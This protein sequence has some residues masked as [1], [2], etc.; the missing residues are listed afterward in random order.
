MK[1]G[2]LPKPTDAEVAILRVLWQR[3]PSTVREVWEQLNP[4][5]RT[6]Y[7]TTLKLMQIMFEK[8]LV[9][10]DD[11]NRSHVYAPAVSE[12]RTQQQVIGHLLERVFAGSAGK[13]VMQ[14]LAVKKASPAELAEIRKLLDK[15]EEGGGA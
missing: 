3:G 4:G 10:R 9:K 12:E 13:L 2:A 15:M 6:G 5:Q 11:T 7:T 8:G 1:K 14:A